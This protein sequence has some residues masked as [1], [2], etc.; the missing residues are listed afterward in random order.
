MQAE[1]RSS[2]LNKAQSPKTTHISFIT[3]PLERGQSVIL[4]I[5]H[6]ACSTFYVVRAISTKFGLHAGNMN[7]NTQ[8][9]E[10]ISIG[11]TI[12]IC[13]YNA[14]CSSINTSCALEMY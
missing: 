8:N 6:Q 4:H 11:L 1:T 9:E 10:R 13:T 7:Y 2:L 5:L 12:I 3:R 14:T